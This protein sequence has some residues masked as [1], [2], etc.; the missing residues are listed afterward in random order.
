MATPRGG[1]AGAGGGAAGGAA[2][3]Q[4]AS[5]GPAGR[6]VEEVLGRAPACLRAERAAVALARPG[7][8]GAE[9][10]PPTAPGA[11]VRGG[12]RL[13]AGLSFEGGGRFR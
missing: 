11:N 1:G 9:G 2:R 7:A 8:L 12:P 3:A 10:A 6:L 5:R 4:A 13:A